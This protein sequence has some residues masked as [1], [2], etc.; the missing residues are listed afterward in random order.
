MFSSKE[1]HVTIHGKQTIS[2]K[3]PEASKILIPRTFKKLSKVQLK[4]FQPPNRLLLFMEMKMAIFKNLKKTNQT[5]TKSLL[6]KGQLLMRQAMSR[7]GRRLKNMPDKLQVNMKNFKKK[8]P[9]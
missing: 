8:W 4:Q 9:F 2:N 3:I 5:M 7:S 1:K 6:R